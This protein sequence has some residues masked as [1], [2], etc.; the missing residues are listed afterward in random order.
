MHLLR[1]PELMKWTTAVGHV[2]SLAEA[3]AETAARPVGDESLRVTGL[4][5]VG[6]LL[7]A[8]QNL[9][10]VRVALVVDL[11][12]VDVPWFCTPPGASRWAEST[13][14]SKNPVTAWWRSGHG[15]VWNHRIVRPALVWDAAGGLREDVVTAL[16][17]GR[18][19]DVGQ[20]PP[21][22]EAFASRMA[23]E[24]EVS[25]AALE[26]RTAD[27]DAK[28]WGRTPLERIADPLF[29]ASLGY[30]DVLRAQVST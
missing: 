29:D 26:A 3:C 7:G 25:R 19:C 17:E 12:P 20:T 18:G 24:L 22:A 27:Y 16:R 5:A 13:R 2:R 15:P 11:P 1:E 9:D 14:L 28:R 8:P 6:D 10:W 21:S 30:V 4:W 23:D